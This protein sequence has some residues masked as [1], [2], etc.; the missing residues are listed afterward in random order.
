[1]NNLST[2][3]LT[4]A[5]KSTPFAESVNTVKEI[6]LFTP[7]EISEME[8]VRQGMCGII[9][10]AGTTTPYWLFVCFDNN[11]DIFESAKPLYN[12]IVLSNKQIFRIN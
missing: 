9:N 12:F 5:L 1:M 8:S 6:T 7:D 10:I 3:D 11:P 2:S 4:N